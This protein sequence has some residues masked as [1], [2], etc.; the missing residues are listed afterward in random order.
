M[1]PPDQFSFEYRKASVLLARTALAAT[2]L[3]P[4]GLSFAQSPQGKPAAGLSVSPSTAPCDSDESIYDVA[5]RTLPAV[6]E[7]EVRGLGLSKRVDGSQVL[8]RQQGLGSGVI[9]DPGG[10]IR[11]LPCSGRRYD[12]SDCSGIVFG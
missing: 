12:D 1:N 10:Y 4:A 11:N 3:A 7:I 8:Q 5:S 6:V 9:V 2:L